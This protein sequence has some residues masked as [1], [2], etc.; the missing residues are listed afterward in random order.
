MCHSLASRKKKLGVS[1][2][3]ENEL[4][5]NLQEHIK[6][7]AGGLALEQGSEQTKILWVISRLKYHKRGSGPNDCK[8]R[9]FLKPGDVSFGLRRPNQDNNSSNRTVCLVPTPPTLHHCHL[10]DMGE[11]FLLSQQIFYEAC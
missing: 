8:Q 1:S 3:S 5:V 6:L 2:P 10:N 9:A 4:F 11:M 7:G